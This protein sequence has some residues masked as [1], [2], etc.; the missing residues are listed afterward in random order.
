MRKA[1]V[2]L[3]FAVVLALVLVVAGKAPGAWACSCVPA[4]DRE[5]FEGADL[6]FSGIVTGR[7]DPNATS[8]AQSSGDD[9]IWTVD[10]DGAQK[11]TV[12][13]PEEV[14]S[15]RNGATCGYEFQI[16][17]RYQVFADR[18]D[19]KVTTGL[20]SGTR[21]LAAGERP[22]RPSGSTKGTITS[23]GPNLPRTGVTPAPSG[24]ALL[25]AAA[26]LA[27]RI[28]RRG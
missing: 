11:G 4:N 27:A 12:S 5:H 9:I 16:T 10:V 18:R 14:V 25:G 6:V 7:E 2:S 20:C 24:A 8:P 22:Y 1:G 3:R 26:L 23:G 15:A 28:R 19:G 17:K 13:D 21:E